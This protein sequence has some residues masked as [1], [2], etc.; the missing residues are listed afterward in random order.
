MPESSYEMS[1]LEEAEPNETPDEDSGE[2]T[3]SEIE[4]VDE[5]GDAVEVE[6]DEVGEPV[7]VVEDAPGG[8]EEQNADS[9]NSGH[10]SDSDSG[11]GD[12]GN[13]T[14]G[15]EDS[16]ETDTAGNATADTGGTG[17]TVNT[18]YNLI[19]KDK[20][21]NQIGEI[22]LLVDDGSV[23]ME[24]SAVSESEWQT[25]MLDNVNLISTVN[26]VLL[27]AL[28]ACFGALVISTVVRSFEW[29]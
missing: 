16:G 23:V 21:G 20:D 27:V 12:S 13:D 24:V 17:D 9:S 29:K 26:V 2:V 3:A 25:S 28:F 22:P 5:N 10:V 8:S 7:R 14:E 6:I 1:E 15:E 11:A 18:N 4:Y 19:L